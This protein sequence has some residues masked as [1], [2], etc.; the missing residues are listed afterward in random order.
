VPAEDLVRRYAELGVHV[1]LNLRRGQDLHIRCYVE[2]APLARAVA[3]VAYEVG[4]R[5]V[6][7]FY[8]DQHVRRGM[9]EHADDD[10]LEWSPPWGF[11]QLEY[12]HENQ[13]AEFGI[14]GD[15]NP[16]IHAGI[17]G[18]RV[19][20]ARPKD[21]L[22]LGADIIF[23]QQ[24]INWSG[25]AYPNAGWAQRIFGEPDVE[26]LWTLVAT[27]VR[28]D[29]PDPV[30]AWKDHLA[31][32]KQRAVALNERHFDAIRFRG[33]GTDLTVGLFPA[34]KWNAA[35]FE[36][37]Y[38]HSFVPNLPTEEVFTTPDPARTEGTVRATRPFSPSGGVVIEG[39]ELRFENGRAVEVRADEG[40]EVVRAQLESDPGS[41]RLGEVALVDGTS[42]VGKLGV[43]FFDVLYDE[44]A[45]C[46]IAYGQ[47][48]AMGVEGDGHVN[49]SGIH[50]DFMIGGPEVDVDGLDVDG[51]AT[52]ILRNDEW[53]LAGR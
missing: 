40:E 6:D 41:A 25:M 50:V 29:E 3:R 37:N 4:A 30:A 17:D 46:H 13:G 45:T 18:T 22:K 43:V 52:P 34:S 12:L 39:L 38:G 28:L 15:P 21:L 49:E 51:T 14:S 26:R 24:T 27:A 32:L 7:V 31:R 11:A 33:P 9:L 1:G 8:G 5:R 23:N 2:H 20:R 44:N 48:L 53:V 36:T 10:V 19:G 47:G 35:E 42:R 16:D